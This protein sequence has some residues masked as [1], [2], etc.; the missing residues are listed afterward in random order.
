M[1][2][3]IVNR[4]HIAALAAFCTNSQD[5]AGRSLKD[6]TRI[7]NILWDANYRSV[8]VRYDEDDSAPVFTLHTADLVNMPSDPVVVIKACHCLEYQSCE[9]EEWPQ[10]EACGILESI[11]SSACHKLSGYEAAPWGIAEL[12][13]EDNVVSLYELATAKT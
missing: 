10:S 1:S 2:A 4:T 3:F 6:G 7:G 11:V 5:W 12:P 9:F 8:N 13:E